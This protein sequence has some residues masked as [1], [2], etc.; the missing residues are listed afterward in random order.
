MALSSGA[1]SEGT[2]AFLPVNTIAQ[3]KVLR[4]KLSGLALV[5]AGYSARIYQSLSADV[6]A[7]YFFRTD[8]YTYNDPEIDSGSLSPLLG[9]E[10]YGG[11]TWAPVSDISFSLGGGVFLPRTG[12]SFAPGTFTRWRVSL[13]TII[14]F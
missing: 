12:N 3:G 5:E 11:L 7:A 6:E 13:E 4:P 10:I 9:G 2:R 1:W 14:S 8:T